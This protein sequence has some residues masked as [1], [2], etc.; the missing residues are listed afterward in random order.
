MWTILTVLQE[1][2]PAFN[3]TNGEAFEKAG[4]AAEANGAAETTA[5]SG[6]AVRRKA[7][8]FLGKGDDSSAVAD[9]DDAKFRSV[10]RGGARR[11]G[12]A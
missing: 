1:E 9:A 10:R 8:A 11:S 3:G 7:S 2:N 4:A 5:A 12:A 6:K